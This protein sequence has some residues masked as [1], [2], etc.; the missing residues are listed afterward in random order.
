[1]TLWR[2]EHLKNNMKARNIF[3]QRACSLFGRCSAWDAMGLRLTKVEA[4][5]YIKGVS[6]MV[7]NVEWGCSVM[8][9]FM[10]IKD[11]KDW[12][13]WN[14]FN[15]LCSCKSLHKQWI[16]LL[17]ITVPQSWWEWISAEHLEEG[18]INWEHIF[19]DWLGGVS[20]LNW[21]LVPWDWSYIIYLSV[22]HLCLELDAHSM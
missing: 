19:N 7:V 13:C 3:T 20:L 9:F 5:C 6:A 17:D 8:V 18:G 2:E 12:F 1:M 15:D 21:G 4:L 22:R 16:T 11:K 10:I 14:T